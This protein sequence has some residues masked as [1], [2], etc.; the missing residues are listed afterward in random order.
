M[1]EIIVRVLLKMELASEQRREIGNAVTVVNERFGEF[2][3]GTLLPFLP[4]R[5]NLPSRRAGLLL[6]VGDVSQ[7]PFGRIPPELRFDV[8][9]NENRVADRTARF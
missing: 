2:D 1:L 7:G 8:E 6:L 3:L 4:T 9:A 5:A